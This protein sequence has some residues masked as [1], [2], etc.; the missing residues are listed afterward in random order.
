VDQKVRE[1]ARGGVLAGALVLF[2]LAAGA[3]TADA[4]SAA[5]V[6]SADS[7]EVQEVVVTGSRLNRPGMTSPTPVTALSTNELALQNPQSLTQGLAQLPALA[8]S[9][10]AGSMGGRTTLGPG[11]FLNL[12]NLGTTRTLILLD[13]ERLAPSNVAG[14]V[15]VNLLP[16]ALVSSVDVVTGGASAAYGSDAVAGVVNYVLNDRF[17]GFKAD[18]NGGVSGHA[19]GAASKVS[20]AWG[21]GFMDDRLHIEGSLDW[22]HQQT[23]FYDKRDWSSQHCGVISTGVTAA[24]A[25]VQ[26]PQNTLA[27]GVTQP[28]SAYGGVL[29]GAPWAT[30]AGSTS[31]G[32]NGVP[33]AFPYGTFRT[34]STQVGGAAD[35]VPVGNVVNFLTPLDTKVLFGRASFKVTSSVEAFAQ[36]TA[37]RVHTPAYPQTPGYFNGST[38][39]TIFSGNPYIPASIQSTMTAQNIKTLSLGVSPFDWGNIKAQ[40]DEET[41][42]ARLGLKGRFGDSYGWDLHVEHAR[43][44]FIE[45][46]V[47]DINLAHVYQAVNA[48][49]GPNG[50]PVCSIT[51]TNPASQCAPLNVFGTNV[52]S[53]AALA[54]IHGQAEQWNVVSQTDVAAN[55]RGEPFSLWA[56]P[57]SLGTGIE[58][59]RLQGSQSSDAV[60]QQNDGLALTGLPAGSYPGSLA[61]QTG[62]WLTANPLPYAGSINVT[63]GYVETLIPLLKDTFLARSLDL[64]AAGRVTSYSQSGTVETW[65]TGLTWSPLEELLVRVTESADIRAP[66]ISDLYS[67]LALGPPNPL[68]G[69]NIPY[70]VSSGTVGNATLKPE[71]ARTF[72]GG[73]TWQPGYLPG[74][75]LSADYYDIKISG[76]LAST[77]AADTVNRCS[78][79]EQIFCANIVRDATNGNV[80]YIVLP[81]ENLSQARTRGIDFEGNYRANLGPGRLSLR[82]I[83]TRL[84]EQSNTTS[85]ATG[86]QYQDQAGSLLISP[87]GTNPN[88]YPHW[89]ANS[90]IGYDIGSFGVDVVTRFV[91]GG[92]YYA[93]EY[94]PT[95]AP[96]LS[97]GPT[98]FDTT[99]QHV[100]SVFTF[101]LGAHYQFASMTGG[102][103][104]YF[105]VTN[106]FD[107]AP[108]I[109]GSS[110]LIGFQTAS[111]MYDT[112]GRYFTLGVRASF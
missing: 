2:P 29:I 5:T 21:H 68:T 89:L 88:S 71:K 111:S 37:G 96:A 61:F 55:I 77:T 94:S 73:F 98:F 92:K 58:W 27:C 42:D 10:V 14:N 86:F 110:T 97:Y 83:A 99:K 65:K 31:F 90:T 100:P 25:T 63:E 70:N 12:R 85:T 105:Q 78:L 16:Q 51:L 1:L 59:R 107:K 33:Q 30:A 91:G 19:D 28:N 62:G 102:P 36:I 112:M 45:N 104:V 67:R 64:N 69:T 76:A 87:G 81:E 47:N 4:D 8:N 95:V 38:P 49:V 109:L 15:D 46:Y 9:T 23:A 72:T 44:Q 79:G 56:G 34:S 17:T 52:A 32:P 43:T 57:V 54:Y 40:N 106:L 93:P 39:F 82:G 80:A 53:P 41:Y 20:L 7:S 103:D 74:L 26:N 66:G 50:S 35:A 13:G 75:S 6:S 11:N 101:N 3:A 24:N 48:V 108:P 60:S 18:V 84:L 22:T